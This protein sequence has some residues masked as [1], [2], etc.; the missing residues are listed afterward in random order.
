[1]HSQQYTKHRLRTQYLDLGDPSWTRLDFG[2]Q[3]G[4]H[5][6]FVKHATTSRSDNRLSRVANGS[7]DTSHLWRGQS[8][9]RC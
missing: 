2:E 9:L 6:Q 7:R 8:R 4:K 3:F 1:M 5:Y